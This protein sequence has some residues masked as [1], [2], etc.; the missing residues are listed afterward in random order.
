MKFKTCLLVGGILLTLLLGRDV[1]GQAPFYQ[2]K[3]ITLIQGGEAGGTGDMRVKAVVPFLRKHIPGNPNILL[4]Y[5]PGAGGRKAGNYLFASARPDGLTVA[6]VG[7]I[8]TSA[9]LGQTGVQYDL[10]K[11]IYLGASN[12]SSHYV[13][14]T[15]GELG[16]NSIEKL[17]AHAVGHFVY[18][19]GRFFAWLIG[20]KDP[21]FVTGCSGVELDVNLQRGEIDSRANIADTVL[22]RNAELLTKGQ[23]HVH[24]ILEIPKG[25]KH[26]HPRFA[27]LPEVERFARSDKE[28]KALAMFRAFRLVGTPYILPPGTPQE[29]AE[30]LREAFRKTL[31]D[32]EF[33]KEY[34]KLTG[35]DAAPLLPEGMETAIRE[36]PRERE[37]AE[38]FQKIAGP[39]ALPPR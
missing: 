35:D 16:L 17:R 13:F 18:I 11:F 24:A 25:D 26:P 2:G 33:H 8:V 6:N 28:S 7:G 19:T 29:R 20:L 10:D 38:L 14:V 3:T 12:A 23:V 39:D 27:S 37:I 36:L 22:Q 31:R 1:R 21:R 4:E 9:V 30:T 5:M 15:R 32:P 34:K